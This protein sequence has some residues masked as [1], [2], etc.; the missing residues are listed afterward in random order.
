M[1]GNYTQTV[2]EKKC[3]GCREVFGAKKKA[4]DYRGY[5][6]YCPKCVKHKVYWTKIPYSKLFTV[7]DEGVVIYKDA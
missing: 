5:Q 2:K 6:D 1:S 3:K 4:G 7:S